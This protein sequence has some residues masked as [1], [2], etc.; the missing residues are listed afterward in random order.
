MT[1]VSLQMGASML[2][3]TTERV[4]ATDRRYWAKLG[5]TGQMRK[6]RPNCNL[7]HDC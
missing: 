6:T 3:H 7:L 4:K 1:I 5:Y 2:Q